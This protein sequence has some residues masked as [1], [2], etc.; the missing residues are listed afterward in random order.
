MNHDAISKSILKGIEGEEEET[1]K[2][3]A[4]REAEAA[5]WRADNEK[6]RIAQEEAIRLAVPRDIETFRKEAAQ[7]LAE[8]DRLEAMLKEF[9]NVRKRTGRWNKVAYYAKDV[10]PL[11]NRFD[12]RHNCG[13]CSDSPLEIWP[14]LET[15]YGNIYSDPPEFRVGEKAYYG[16]DVPHKGWDKTMRDAGLP[17]SIIGAVSMHF[18][19]SAERAKQLAEDIYDGEKD[20][21]ADEPPV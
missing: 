5:K 16:G 4:A 10:N 21:D 14:Y 19:G 17:E 1:P 7:K 15:P 2:Q 13:C 12:M 6:R 8:A 20:P 9:P 18:R 11:V 3:A